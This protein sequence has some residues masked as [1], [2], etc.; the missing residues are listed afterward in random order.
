MADAYGEDNQPERGLESEVGGGVAGTE[1]VIIPLADC[2]LLSE[3]YINTRQPSA[4]VCL[5]PSFSERDPATQLSRPWI[6]FLADVTNMNR[7]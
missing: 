2:E 7:A 6:R 3:F 1:L 4:M 5:T